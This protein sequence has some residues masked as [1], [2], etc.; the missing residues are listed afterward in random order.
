R[1]SGGVPAVVVAVAGSGEEIE[2][3]VMLAAATAMVVA[4]G[5]SDDGM[6]MVVPV[7]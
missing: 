4:S 5:C 3:A 6:K 1:R 2:V 7:E